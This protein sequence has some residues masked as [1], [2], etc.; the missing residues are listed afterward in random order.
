MQWFGRSA[1]VV[2]F[3]TTMWYVFATQTWSRQPSRMASNT[4]SGRCETLSWQPRRLSQFAYR[5]T[6]GLVESM[7]SMPGPTWVLEEVMVTRWGCRFL[8]EPGFGENERQS[9]GQARG[10]K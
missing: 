1:A 10:R 4:T 6:G 3:R 7:D 5:S 9:R 2:V 8:W